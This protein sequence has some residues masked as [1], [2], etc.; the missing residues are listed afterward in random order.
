MPKY[1][2]SVARALMKWSFD[3]KSFTSADFNLCAGQNYAS[4]WDIIK[5]SQ[6]QRER[7][8]KEFSEHRR[9]SFDQYF[10]IVMF[11]CCQTS[12]IYSKSSIR[13][14]N[15]RA[16]QMFAFDYAHIIVR[17]ITLL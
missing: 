11:Y 9:Q 16:W 14:K 4:I 17:M 2:G 7:E 13:L 12:Q 3:M 1:D 6:Q 5:S 10:L 8:R 15:M